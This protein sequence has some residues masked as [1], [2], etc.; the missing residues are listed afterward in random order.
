MWKIFF[1]LLNTSFRAV[2]L[3]SLKLR[4][5]SVFRL[6]CFHV[7]TN[8][9]AHL[10]LSA[11]VFLWTRLT[12]APLCENP[13]WDGNPRRSNHGPGHFLL[14]RPKI[15]A[16]TVQTSRETKQDVGRMIYWWY[17]TN[18][19][20]KGQNIPHFYSALHNT[21]YQLLETKCIFIR[22]FTTQQKHEYISGISQLT[23]CR[24]T[25]SVFIRFLWMMRNV[26][27][28][29][30][31]QFSNFYFSSY[32]ENSSKIGVMGSQ[33]NDHSSKNQNR[34]C[35]FSFDSADSISFM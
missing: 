2:K 17:A 33:K 35:D 23:I 5:P 13:V 8:S 6:V 24:P 34:K 7:L 29:M 14:H 1:A 22:I 27:K 10:Q 26:L 3:T 11:T 15:N 18:V 16:I 9:P 30:K 12:T 4:K 20:L 31:N 19:I 21:Q 25:P 28:R 32:R